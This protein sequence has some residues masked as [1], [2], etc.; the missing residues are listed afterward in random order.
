[1]RH[2]DEARLFEPFGEFIFDY[3]CN[4]NPDHQLGAKGIS[5]LDV[6]IKLNG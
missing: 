3:R 4:V 5:L 2:S 6:V 1:M